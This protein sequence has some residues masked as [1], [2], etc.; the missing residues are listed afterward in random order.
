[1]HPLQEKFQVMAPQP[2][3]DGENGKWV[4]Q[5]C[6]RAAQVFRNNDWQEQRSDDVD[7]RQFVEMPHGM[8]IDQGM[9]TSLINGM[10]LSMAGET[11]VT[12]LTT[13]RALHP[14]KGFTKHEMKGTDD[15]YTGEHVDHFYGDSGG[16]VE[17][18]N[19]LDRM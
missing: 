10:P 17:R 16:F 11:D 3:T 8:E 9:V 19:Y 4:S 2:K 13:P 14:D 7:T 1:M 15:C 5:T 6:A 18:N 12:N